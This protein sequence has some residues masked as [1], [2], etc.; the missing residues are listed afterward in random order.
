MTAVLHLTVM[1]ILN[2]TVKAYMV[3]VIKV[4]RWAEVI[5]EVVMPEVRRLARPI[6]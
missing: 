2:S 6:R 1:H 5:Q 4:I 3:A